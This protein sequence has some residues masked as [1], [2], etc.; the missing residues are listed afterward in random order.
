MGVTELPILSYPSNNTTIKPVFTLKGT[1]KRLINSPRAAH[2]PSKSPHYKSTGHNLQG[3][4]TALRKNREKP[5]FSL[6]L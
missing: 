4:Q 3:Q 5:K 6:R 2:E 1:G